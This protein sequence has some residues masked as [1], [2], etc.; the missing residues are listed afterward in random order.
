MNYTELKNGLNPLMVFSGEEYGLKQY[1]LKRFGYLKV[2]KEYIINTLSSIFPITKKYVW[3]N[4]TVDIK[5]L[6]KASTV[7]NIV[8]V[9]DD[10]PKELKQYEVEFPKLSHAELIR[11]IKISHDDFKRYE[12]LDIQNINDVENVA[13][14]LEHD[15][16]LQFLHIGKVPKKSDNVKELYWR[17]F[18][19]KNSIYYHILASALKGRFDIS[20]LKI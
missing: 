8:L 17:Y 1:Y 10:C 3:L 14:F 19:T 11:F 20:Q 18:K 12:G 6:E 7:Y 2:D 9:L 16:D 5:I 15:L 13:H 4:E